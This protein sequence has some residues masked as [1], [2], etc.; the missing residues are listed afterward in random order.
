MVLLVLLVLL[1]LLTL[2]VR[3]W[4]PAW[5]LC[6]GVK[7]RIGL[8]GVAKRRQRWPRVLREELICVLHLL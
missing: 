2:L 8:V 6:G 1:A 4:Q 5:V 7:G 3:G